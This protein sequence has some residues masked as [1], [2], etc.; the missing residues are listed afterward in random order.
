MKR[1]KVILM[2]IMFCFILSIDKVKAT[3]ELPDNGGKISSSQIIQTKTGTG[4]FDEND[5]P[6]ND[7]SED[8]NVVRS[9]DQVT[10]TVENTMILNGDGATSYTGGRIHFEAVLPSAFTKETIEWDIDSMGWIENPQVSSDG[11]TLT[12]YYQMSNE[13]IT[14]PGKQSLIFIAKLYGAANGIKFQPTIN[15]WLNGNNEEDYQTVI[16][17]EITVSAK[18][19]YNLKLIKNGFDATGYTDING[20]KE[21][22]GRLNGYNVILQLHGDNS[23]KGLKGIEYPKGKITF[24]V[25]LNLERYDLNGENREI[26]TNLTDILLYDYSYNGDQYSYSIPRTR[27]YS[28]YRSANIPYGNRYNITNPNEN[29]FNRY[30]YNS[31]NINIEQEDNV[32]HVTIDNYDFDGIFPSRVYDSANG[33]RFPDNVGC[34]S[35]C[36]FETFIVTNDQTTNDEKIYYFDVKLKNMKA[37]SISGKL[38]TNQKVTNDDE[39]KSQYFSY[40][41]GT[42]SSSYYFYDYKTDELLATLWSRADGVIYKNSKVYGGMLLR[43]SAN[44]TSKNHIIRSVNILYKFDTNG[45]EIAT[46]DNGNKFKDIYN[47]FKFN[48]YY[49]AKKDGTGWSSISEQNSARYTDLK[50]YNTLEELYADG[51]EVCVAVLFESYDGEWYCPDDGSDF[52]LKIPLNVKESSKYGQTYQET[53]I[54]EFYTNKLDRSK[55]SMI[56]EDGDYVSKPVYTSFPKNYI[57]TEYDEN[58]VQVSGTHNSVGYG[59][60]L[61]IVGAESTIKK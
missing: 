6:G 3:E 9:F 58:G 32:L 44:N 43:Q 27:Q 31:G 13:N 53:G 15:L 21:V 51:N 23:A 19:S 25:E 39:S 1:F 2:I 49:A 46:C 11:L 18:P 20:Q 35:L 59:N 50:Y 54:V 36:C 4:P 26:I 57:K 10:W 34:F 17:E 33:T 61:L 45:F 55:E 38:V 7:S 41:D 14:V 37:N 5:D 22:E 8:N 28:F 40:I 12:G 16:P 60:A 52:Y 56:L 29:N 24:D 47:I 30:I 48:M 42:Y